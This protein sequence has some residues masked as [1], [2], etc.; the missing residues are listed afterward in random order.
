MKKLILLTAIL[1]S[2]TAN[3]AR[4]VTTCKAGHETVFTAEATSVK[5]LQTQTNISVC[6]KHRI[7]KDCKYH[8]FSASMNCYTLAK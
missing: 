4:Y 8:T 2:S 7:S 1:V 5:Y 3:A 6:P